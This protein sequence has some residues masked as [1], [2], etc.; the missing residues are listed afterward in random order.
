MEG[1]ST[2]D[3]I[4]CQHM[5]R[6]S[7]CGAC[8]SS[9]SGPNNPF[10]KVNNDGTV[11][12]SGVKYQPAP[13][14]ARASIA[15]VELKATTTA[16]D[17]GE[18]SDW[19]TNNNDASWGNNELLD[20][21]KFLLAV[22]NP[23]LPAHKDLPLYLDS[24]ASTHMS[25]MRLDFSA[26]KSIEPQT[27]TGVGN[28]SISAIGMGTIEIL[29][30]ETSACLTLRNVL[31]APDASICLVSISQLDDSGHQ[32]SFANRRC[33]LLDQSSGRK[34]AECARNLS[35]LYVLPGS[36]QSIPSSI[37]CPAPCVALPALSATPNLET[38]HWRLGHA[39]FRTV[40]DMAHG[41]VVTGMQ[42]N[43]SLTLQACDACTVSM[44]N[45]HINRFQ[46]CMRDKRQIGVLD[47]SL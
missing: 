40:L 37:P 7:L 25:C 3:A 20:T 5:A 9:S 8:P 27:I 39:N 13:E 6:E 1:L 19:A 46:S 21:A 10:L 32:L 11:W 2:S 16:A 30:P 23:S 36:I 24:G 4:A 43:L 28:L 22:T 34:L 41:N 33:T 26:F 44:A 15:E 14:P 47:A 35:H 38:W 45:R 18:Y 42:A 12:I 29:I 31:Y 17:Q